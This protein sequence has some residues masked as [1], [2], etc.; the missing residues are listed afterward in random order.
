MPSIVKSLVIVLFWYSRSSSSIEHSD[1]SSA[2]AEIKYNVQKT[3]KG[4]NNPLWVSDKCYIYPQ[5]MLIS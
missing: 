3:D 4:M 5:M 2:L 1:S